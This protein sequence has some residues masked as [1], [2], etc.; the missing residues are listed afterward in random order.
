MASRL[1]IAY[2]NGV[3]KTA[4]ELAD[5][6]RKVQIIIDGAIAPRIDLR[7]TDEGSFLRVSFPSDVAEEQAEACFRAAV[8]I[9]GLPESPLAAGSP[10]LETD[11]GGED[12][13]SPSQYEYSV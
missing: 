9:A 2:K 1:D 4:L 3:N 7:P 11:P 6:L 5:A 12:L 10:R 8:N 13:R